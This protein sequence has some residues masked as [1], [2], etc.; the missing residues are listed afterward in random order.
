MAR[1][2]GEESLQRERNFKAGEEHRGRD[3]PAPRVERTAVKSAKP[4]SSRAICT[5][6]FNER[7]ECPEEGW[8]VGPGRSLFT[9]SVT[10]KLGEE[11]RAF[12]ATP[13]PTLSRRPLL[14][15]RL[16]R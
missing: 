4:Q 2:A 15:A 9:V 12:A 3:A 7:S 16:R 1:R 6:S 11:H 10:T 13:P 8:P 14:R 5:P